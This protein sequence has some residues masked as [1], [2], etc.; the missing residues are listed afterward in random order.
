[1]PTFHTA[2]RFPGYMW[3]ARKYGSFTMIPP[4]VFVANL[5]TAQK[6]SDVP[7]CV[8]ECG[9]WRGGMIAGMAEVLGPDRRYVLFD[10]FEGLPP[11]QAI[12][13][14]SA[15]AWQAN[16]NAAGYH[17]NC[18]AEMAHAERAMRL[19]GA[20]RAELVKGWFDQSVPTFKFDEPIAVLRLDGD[21]YESTMTCL[22]ALFDRVH[23]EGVIILDDYYVW[24]GCSR[25]VHR[26]LA[27]RES[28]ARID[29][30]FHYVCVIKK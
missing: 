7:G 18:R 25:A 27:D 11:A 28:T 24:D 13:G 10:S 30:S 5:A 8:V 3:L 9:V 19:A 4:A 29:R 12:D 21:W 14:T 15:Q 26:F 22:E 1:M 2:A 20:T 23:P 16:T 17:D 6:Y